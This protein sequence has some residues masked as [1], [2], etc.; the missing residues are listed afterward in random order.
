MIKRAYDTLI[1]DLDGTLYQSPE[2]INH[3]TELTIDW[4]AEKSNLAQRTPQSF[5]QN[6][7]DEFQHP[8]DGFT[9]IGLTIDNYF[10]NVSYNITP[11][12]FVDKNE[13]LADIL[14]KTEPQLVIISLA[15]HS[16]IQQMT[17][18]IGISKYISAIYNPYQDANSHSKYS[19]YKEFADKDVLV[20]GDSY[21]RDIQPA[22]ELEFD[23]VH[24]APD[25]P[26]AE[27]HAC[28]DRIEEIENYVL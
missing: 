27:D 6:L 7:S 24:L 25:C 26:I 3:R 2:L 21:A 28:I 12:E 16:Y 15:P 11:S 9:S 10:E 8:Y 22:L 18:A 23:T 5:Y 17:D 20:T 19:I 14:S 4:I 1:F 13:S